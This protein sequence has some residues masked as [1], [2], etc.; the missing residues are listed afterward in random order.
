MVSLA[1]FLGLQGA[2]LL[3]IGE[4]GTIPIRNEAILKIMNQNMSVALGWLA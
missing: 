1:F 4:A 2:M 3:I